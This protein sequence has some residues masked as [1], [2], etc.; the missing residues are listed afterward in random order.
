MCKQNIR[1]FHLVKFTGVLRQKAGGTEKGKHKLQDHKNLACGLKPAFFMNL[2]S[3]NILS[4][5]LLSQ[6]SID[7]LAVTVTKQQPFIFELCTT[8][9]GHF[10]ASSKYVL[11]CW[12]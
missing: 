5:T 11:Y 6:P 7:D 8:R 10:A 9:L 12:S 2:K 4:N 1:G 3:H